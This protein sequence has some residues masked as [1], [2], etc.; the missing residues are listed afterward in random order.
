MHESGVSDRVVQQRIRNR[1]IDYLQLASSFEEQREYAATAPVNIPYE[2]INQW[3]D[4]VSEDPRTAE[5]HSDVY[6]GEEIEALGRVHTV[7]EAAAAQL[8]DDYPSI[9]EAQ[10]LP[11]WEALRVEAENAL[12]VFMQHGRMPED[13]EQV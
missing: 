4:W 8:P 3:E 9:L 6:S 1:V 5:E 10:A 7:W 13:I 11:A 12:A 2:V